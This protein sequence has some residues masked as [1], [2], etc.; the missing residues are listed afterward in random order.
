V[1]ILSGH[2]ENGK[3]D[4]VSNSSFKKLVAE[5]LASDVFVSHPKYNSFRSVWDPVL[6]Y[7]FDKEDTF[8]A[9]LQKNNFDKFDTLKNILHTEI[10][11]NKE[12]SKNIETYLQPDFIQ[13]VDAVVNE[14]IAVYNTQLAVYNDRFKSSALALVQGN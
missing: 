4:T 3:N 13:K 7:S 11:K 1:S 9:D 10:L 14:D 2:L 5:S 6:N 8:I 12:F